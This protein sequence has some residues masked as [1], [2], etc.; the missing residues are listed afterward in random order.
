MTFVRHTIQRSRKPP[1]V[2]ERKGAPPGSFGIAGYHKHA[3]EAEIHATIVEWF[4]LA[5][6]CL[7]FHIPNEGR[8]SVSGAALQKRL[9]LVSGAPDLVVLMPC[10]RMMMI[11]VK[12]VSGILSKEQKSFQSWCDSNNHIYVVCRS[13]DDVQRAM[14]HSQL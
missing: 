10:G 2:V 9:G 8:R 6:E 3:T 5:T 12:T 14:S 4:N 1:I 13:L 11:E 7:V